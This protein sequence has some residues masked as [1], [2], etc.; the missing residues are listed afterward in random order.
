[1]CYQVQNFTENINFIQYLY[2]KT[3]SVIFSDFMLKYKAA[4]TFYLL[5]WLSVF[6]MV[7]VIWNL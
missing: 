1:M 7:Y 6:C 4:D 5:V 3:V 2:Y